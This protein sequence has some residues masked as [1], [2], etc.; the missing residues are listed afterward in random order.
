MPRDEGHAAV[1]SNQKHTDAELRAGFEALSH[2]ATFSAGCPPPDRLWDGA[3]GNLTSSDVESLALHVADCGACAEA[4][5]IA[6]DFGT[7]AKFAKPARGIAW[8]IPVTA[9][10]LLAVGASVFYVMRRAEMNVTRPP[11]PAPPPATPTFAMVVEKAPIQITPPGPNESQVFVDELKAALEPYERGDY[12]AA[13]S[14][15]AACRARHPDKAEP[16]F[17]QGVSLLLAGNAA[18]A[19][20]PLE[21]ARD[22]VAAPQLE[23]ATWYLAAAYERAG[24]RHDALRFAEAICNLQGPRSAAACAAAAALRP[25]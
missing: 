20:E 17:Y 4:W 18:A 24:R 5:R 21:H 11:A 2:D 22:L 10:T 23:D 9:V 14:T 1:I 15:L 25:R 6:Q 3:R 7:P 8:W 16:V 12:P 19:I 13:A